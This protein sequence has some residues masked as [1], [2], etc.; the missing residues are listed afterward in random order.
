MPATEYQRWRSCWSRRDSR[1]VREDGGASNELVRLFSIGHSNHP[2]ERF[3]SLLT[4][5]GVQL[6][7]DVRSSPWS[8]Y[9]SQ[10]NRPTLEGS[11]AAA[12]VEYLFLGEELG[13]RPEGDQFF[14]AEG[15]VLYE[16]VAASCAFAFGIDMLEREARARVVVMMCSEEDPTDCHRRLLV[17]RVLMQQ[18]VE[19]T[20][21]RGDDSGRVRVV[22]FR[23][24]DALR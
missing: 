2:I 9:A 6:L 16:E 1:V 13:G 22:G 15:H 11:L 3:L 20:H 14:D 23:P 18:G 12:G 17:T 8:R 10:F 24:A 21:L 7:V 5:H 4:T 19:V